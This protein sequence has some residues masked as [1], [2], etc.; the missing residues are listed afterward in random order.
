MAFWQDKAALALSALLHAAALSGR[1]VLDIWDWANRS[2]DAIGGSAL[3]HHPAASSVLRSV[4]A[5]ATREGRSPDSIRMTMAKSLTWVAVPSVAA[6]VAGPAARPFDAARFAAARGTLYLVAPGTQGVVIEPLF[7]CFVDFAQRQ[8]TLAGLPHPG[9]Q[10]GPA[11][12]ARPG[13]GPPDRPRPA[14]RVA[15]RLRR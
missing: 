5:E 4:F 7:R 12:A 10:A 14:G 11:A 2:G 9:G 1:T 13:R 3:A 8:A 15:G 6:M